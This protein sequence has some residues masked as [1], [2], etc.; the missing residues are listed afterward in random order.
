MNEL[1]AVAGTS[2]R[3]A[4]GEL[5]CRQISCTSDKWRPFPRL[6]LCKRRSRSARIPLAKSDKDP[7][8]LPRARR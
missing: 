8:P 6:R 7:A 3:T 1:V 2:R 5:P 4:E